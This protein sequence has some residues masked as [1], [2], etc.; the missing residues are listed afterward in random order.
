ML[1]VA[2]TLNELQT[3]NETREC[4]HSQFIFDSVFSFFFLHLSERIEKSESRRAL[5]STSL[6]ET[7]LQ[8]FFTKKDVRERRLLF[9]PAA[10]A[11]DLNPG[12][13][14]ASIKSSLSRCY[15]VAHAAE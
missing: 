8:T 6:P 2:S 7:F 10:R 9:E 12:K 5:V 14:R 3:L 15:R 11:R 4:E 1:L 13:L